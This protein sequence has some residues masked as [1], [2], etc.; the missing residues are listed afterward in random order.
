MLN[1]ILTAIAPI[2]GCGN[3]FAKSKIEGGHFFSKEYTTMLK[4]VC[5]LLVIYVHFVGS[6]TNALQDAIGSFA[7]IAVT[8]FFVTSAYGMMLNAE[9][10][11]DYL[12]T[13][14]RNRLVA[15]LV[16]CLCVNI[17]AF[18]L[19]IVKNDFGWSVLY[20]INQYVV[21][22]LQFCVWF[23]IVEFSMRRWFPKRKSLGDVILISGVVISSLYFYF[24]KYHDPSA[25][26][27]WCFE[28]MGL[29][30]GILLY[31]Y[32]EPFV[33]W[34]DKHRMMKAIVLCLISA[35]L[36]VTYLKYNVVWFW[37]EYLLKVILGIAIILFLFT[38][39]SNRKI[40]NPFG[41]W[42][43]SISFEIYLSHEIVMGLLAFLI[44]DMQ[45]GVFILSTVI[46]TTLLSWGIHSVD[47]AIV[48]K[49]R[50]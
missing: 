43:G 46:L 21:V 18:L 40:G 19:N 45:S 15:L 7:Y 12:K 22:L 47:K 29:V 50:C 42:L 23:Y 27:G 2:L 37:G 35:I 13:F 30:W 33:E 24:N 11:K 10:K 1:Y 9:R 49:F 14:W 20:F 8:L 41:V 32:F 31:R 44:P 34:M 16:P 39:T 28:R 25:A 5:C 4:G 48:G 36:G 6:H 38:A 17:V 26:L 3:F